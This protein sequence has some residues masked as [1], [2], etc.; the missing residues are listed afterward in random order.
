MSIDVEGIIRKRIFFQD[1]FFQDEIRE[2]FFIEKKMKHAWAAQMEVLKEIDRICKRN[3]IR[4]FADSG[5]LLG[6]VRHKGFIP[7]DDDI[8][9]AMLREDYLRFFS[10]ADKELPDGWRILDLAHGSDQLFGR[11]TNGDRYDSGADHMLRFHG[12]P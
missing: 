10:V 8:D 12:C 5:T 9:L 7:W 6:A 2:D 1:A 4:Y 3:E 11:I